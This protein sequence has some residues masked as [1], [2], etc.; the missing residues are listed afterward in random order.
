[1]ISIFRRLDAGEPVFDFI[2]KRKRW[3]WVSAVLLLLSITSFI[4]REIGRAHV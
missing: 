4:V 3:Y 1:M 2:G